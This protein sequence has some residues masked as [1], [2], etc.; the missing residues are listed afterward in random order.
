MS[1]IFFEYEVKETNATKYQI[2]SYT[3]KSVAVNICVL[4]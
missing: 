2:Y 3:I 4:L 1:L